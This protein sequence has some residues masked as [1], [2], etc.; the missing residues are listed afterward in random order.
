MTRRQHQRSPDHSHLQHLQRGQHRQQLSGRHCRGA[1]AT[2]GK[3]ITAT[4]QTLMLGTAK[5]LSPFGRANMTVFNL[6]FSR[7]DSS[8]SAKRRRFQGSESSHA[9][10]AC[11][12][13]SNTSSHSVS[14]RAGAQPTSCVCTLTSPCS[15][16]TQT[17]QPRCCWLQQLTW[18][19][20]PGELHA[21][22]Q[23]VRAADHLVVSSLQ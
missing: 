5:S 17:I 8:S 7:S 1:P 4:P 15:S 23:R 16:L 13:T 22:F 19:R 6:P 10:P 21:R 9:L 12:T 11:I 20:V 2:P 18:S 14:C 3:H